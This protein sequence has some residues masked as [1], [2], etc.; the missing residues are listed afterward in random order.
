MRFG[1]TLSA[2]LVESRTHH[3]PAELIRFRGIGRDRKTSA[4]RPSVAIGQTKVFVDMAG[5]R[6]THTYSMHRARS[7]HIG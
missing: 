7:G 3:A 2:K 1:L 4:K 6:T 5:V